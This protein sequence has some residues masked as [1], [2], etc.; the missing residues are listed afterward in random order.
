MENNFSQAILTTD[1]KAS[2]T[3]LLYE[4]G[5][6][7]SLSNCVVGFDAGDTI[8]STVINDNLESTLL[9]EKNVF[10]VDGMLAKA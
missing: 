5:T 8:R 7:C 9:Q 1:G 6:T 3:I 2:F 4:N 10:R